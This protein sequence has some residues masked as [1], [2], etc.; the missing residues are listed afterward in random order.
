M[1]ASFANIFAALLSRQRFFCLLI[2]FAS[3]SDCR[4]DLPPSDV[5]CCSAYYRFRGFSPYI[6]AA[7][8]YHATLRFTR[9]DT[10]LADDAAFF[11]C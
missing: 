5:T 2:F 4:F 9:C 7:L 3:I 10:P 6:A 11:F 8:R 1:S